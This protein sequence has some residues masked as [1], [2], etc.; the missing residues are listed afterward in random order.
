MLKLAEKQT[1]KGLECC[2]STVFA[3]YFCKR[4]N[5]IQIVGPTHT[6]IEVG[7]NELFLW[8][9]FSSTQRFV[10]RCSIILWYIMNTASRDILL[11]NAL[12]WRKGELQLYLAYSLT[13]EDHRDEY[14]EKYGCSLSIVLGMWSKWMGER[15][16]FS[17]SHIREIS[18]WGSEKYLCPQPQ[19]IEACHMWPRRVQMYGDG[20]E[21]SH[22]C[23]SMCEVMPE[24]RSC[25]GSR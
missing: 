22:I 24:K 7:M 17:S 25:R 19:S 5:A 15:V 9:I 11:L 21:R 4:K 1:I 10:L 12:W 13:W 6:L 18:I 23:S 8:Y 14:Q 3:F 2:L 20:S 16:F